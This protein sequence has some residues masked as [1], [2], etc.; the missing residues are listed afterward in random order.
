[1]ETTHTFAVSA[2]RRKLMNQCQWADQESQSNISAALGASQN[3]GWVSGLYTGLRNLNITSGRNHYHHHHRHLQ[4]WDISQL[5][6]HQTLPPK[7]PNK[8]VLYKIKN[9]EEL[10]KQRPSFHG[11]AS[12]IAMKIAFLRGFPLH[13]VCTQLY[14]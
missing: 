13:C 6:Q 3:K 12:K 10:S 5:R 11:Y 14:L 2:S 9:W 4:I 8:L 7:K 1:M